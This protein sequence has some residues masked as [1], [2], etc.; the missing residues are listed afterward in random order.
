VVS[1]FERSNKQW[2][3]VA[4]L[5]RE[6]IYADAVDSEGRQ[7]NADERADGGLSGIGSITVT[8]A[9]SPI[10]KIRKESCRCTKASVVD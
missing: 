9:G 7:S 4:G 2:P 6:S 10:R 8:P 1:E 3:R 5:K